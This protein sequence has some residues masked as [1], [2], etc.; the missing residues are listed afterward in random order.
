[1]PP[2]SSR[3]QFLRQVTIGSLAVAGA[4]WSLTA[5]GADAPKAPS[6]TPW[7]RRA[8]RWGQTNLA[9]IDAERFD[10]PFWRAHWKRTCV[11][12]IV[13]N[14]G[15]IV[16]YYPTA[17]PYHRRSAY[18]G[19]RDLFGEI[20]RAAQEDGIA[21]LARMD[22]NRADRD[23]FE[24]QPDWFARD[25]AGQ[26]YRST[27]LYVACVNGPYYQQHLPA[28]L[29]EI[30]T[31]YHPD[32][33][34]DNNWNGLFREQPCFCANCREQF[35]QRTGADI[36]ARPDWDSPV[37][38]EWIE[39]NYERRLAIWDLFGATCRDAGGPDC[40]WSGMV[41]GSPEW[42]SRGFR[43]DREIFRRAQIVMLDD[44]HRS[45]AEGF[46]HNGEVG[47]RIRA[48]A[49]WDKVLPESMAM[50]EAA[51][52]NFRLSAMP[53]AEVRLWALEAFAGGVQPWWHHL[54]SVQEDRRAYDSA[55]EIWRWH[56]EHEEFLVNRRPVATIGVVWTQRNLDYFGREDPRVL[57]S[58]PYNG[59]IQALVRARLPYVPVHLDDIGEATASLGLRALILANIG[60][61][62]DAQAEAIRSFAAAGGG[63]LA[64]GATSIANEHGEA[65]PDFALADLFGA[66]VGA[67][68][69][70]GQPAARL[71]AARGWAQTY[72]RLPEPASSRAAPLHGF[73]ETSILPFGGTL[74]PLRIDAGARVGFTFV[75]PVPIMP[76]EEV[77]M[78]QPATDIPGLVL[79][80]PAV[81]GRIAY[82]PAD[83]DR[84]F[85]HDYLPDHG[86][87]LANI[88]RWVV[89]DDV[90]LD[91]RG[92]GL[93]DVHLYRQ[94]GR[95][96]LH[97]VN[98]TNAGT[99][100]Q[101]TD[102]L[103]RIGPVAVRVRLPKG[104]Q[105]T[106]RSLV[107]PSPI[108]VRAGDDAVEFELPSILDHE[109]LVLG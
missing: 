90:P 51:E 6:E 41:S 47:L 79:R 61:M 99:W 19:H 75:P 48:V 68:H 58:Q 18:L 34:T 88:V 27:E 35:H 59:I 65:R 32:G 33:F 1:M 44:Q 55:P 7:Y 67:N 39:W 17:I 12:G 4:R 49:G 78:R 64:T 50:Y 13:V 46:Q 95:L 87:L 25:A 40:T 80:E 84:R 98:L 74:G 85:A 103:I 101:P 82:L 102:Q 109:V 104:I 3:R 43:N 29:R 21:V 30:A 31:R 54:G 5:T 81:G 66:H 8:Y 72:L 60:A 63:V 93:I 108:S 53:A 10:L 38:R 89:R 77:W 11:Q 62:S 52:H 28:I 9:E 76:P 73:D 92:A 23:L 20:R 14:A 106:V 100:R 37:Y 36:P 105:A 22:S 42:E 71:A 2:D 15:G 69:E 26:A 83:L 97:L 45:D 107:S 70:Y 16:A 94:A 57:V 86:D 24:A 96:V 91:V 56:R